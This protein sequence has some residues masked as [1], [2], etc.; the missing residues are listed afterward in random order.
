MMELSILR[1]TDNNPREQSKNDGRRINKQIRASEVRLVME[2]G[3]TEIVS[4]QQ[5]LQRA[6]DAGLDLIEVSPPNTKT[7]VC[8]IADYGRMMYE[9]RQ[10]EKEAKKKQ[11]VTVIKDVNVSPG[12]TQGDFETKSKAVRNFIEK[13]HK[14]KLLVTFKGREINNKERGIAILDRLAQE[15]DDIAKVESPA[16]LDGRKMIMFLSPK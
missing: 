13:K 14:V 12:I 4:I 11:Q 9:I 15:M 1:T 7:P 8:K 2:Q 3:E 10:K 16:K 5:A 6:A